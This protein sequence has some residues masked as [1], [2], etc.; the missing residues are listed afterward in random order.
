MSDQKPSPDQAAAAI[1][2]TLRIH[3]EV[4]G[5]AIRAVVEH[6]LDKLGDGELFLVVAFGFL[7]HD[8][9]RWIPPVAKIKTE[10]YIRRGNDQWINFAFRWA[11]EIEGLDKIVEDRLTSFDMASLISVSSQL[12]HEYV[13]N[14]A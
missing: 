4:A 8:G 11:S 2:A 10:D 14:R 13:L 7:V 3:P 5:G 1:N 12:Q 6:R 9:W